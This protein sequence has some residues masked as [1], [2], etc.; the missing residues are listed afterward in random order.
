VITLN[1]IW[2]DMIG[3]KWPKDRIYNLKVSRSEILHPS[4]VKSEKEM[5]FGDCLLKWLTQIEG[6]I[7]TMGERPLRHFI[8]L[9]GHSFWGRIT[10][11][12]GMRIKAS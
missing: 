10:G 12:D 5:W 9:P 4:Y 6:I 2:W 1:Y 8:D 7:M 3:K 11:T